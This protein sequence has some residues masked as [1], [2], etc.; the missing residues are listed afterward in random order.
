MIELDAI[1]AKGL[2]SSMLVAKHLAKHIMDPA[3]LP[4]LGPS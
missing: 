4:F 1:N 2:K 3:N